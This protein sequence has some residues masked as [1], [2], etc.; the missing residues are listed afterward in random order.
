[1][2]SF[3]LLA[4]LALYI[5]VRAA[6]SARAHGDEW[7]FAIIAAAAALRVA[8]GIINQEMGPLP[9][10]EIDAVAYSSY[11]REI[12][13]AARAGEGFTFEFGR[14]GYASML[15]VF[16]LLGGDS[17]LIPTFVNAVFFVEF[18]LIVYGLATE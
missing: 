2:E 10:A 15:A 4:S 14:F 17:Y 11:G 5:Y 7:L 8:V 1:M 9:G 13:A 16:H 6:W 18:L 12:A 3:V